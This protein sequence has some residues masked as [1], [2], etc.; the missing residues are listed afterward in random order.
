MN[1]ATP[2]FFT[3]LTPTF[4]RA[5]LLGRV[6]ASLQAQRFTDFE[7]LIV[8][9]GSTDD[10]RETVSAMMP[11]SPFP[12]RYIHQENGH[13]K[14]AFNRGVR[15]A[16]GTMLVV[17]D[18]D[19]EMPPDALGT[20]H[21]IWH[22]IPAA[23]RTR[24]VGV[25]GL[26]ARVDGRIVGDRFPQSVMDA[27]VTDMYFRHRVRG[28][29]FGCQRTD[30]LRQFPFPEDIQAF[31]PESLVWWR[32]A[33]A[34]FINRFTNTV[35]RTYHATPTSLSTGSGNLARNA[36]GLYLLNWQLVNDEMGYFIRA[37]KTFVLGAVR[38]TRFALWLRQSNERHVL[39]DYPIARWPAKL[40]VALMWPLGWLLHQRDRRGARLTD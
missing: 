8:D 16:R 23:D 29:K 2:P 30:V 18:D 27:S 32:I 9:D 14:M 24:F 5:D 34:G 7:W 10:T 22:D 25:T 12:V 40:L 1:A 3:V 35:L 39:A 4:N 21:R 38:V 15:E 20:M 31:V 11:R 33:R 6:Y 13:K 26:C 36:A 17:L 37:P 28:E 19:D